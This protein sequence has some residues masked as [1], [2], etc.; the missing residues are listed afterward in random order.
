MPKQSKGLLP[1]E[2][3]KYMEHDSP[4]IYYY[5]DKFKEY[6]VMKRYQWE[7]VPLLPKI[8]IH[9]LRKILY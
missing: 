6:S 5:P 2:Y 9:L 4:L 1:D 3:K 7:C 8:N